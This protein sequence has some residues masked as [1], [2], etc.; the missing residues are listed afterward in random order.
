MAEHRPHPWE[1]AWKEGRWKELSPP[2]P[3]V[4]EFA[5]SLK[6]R[7][8]IRVLDLGC[9]AGRHTLFL[10]KHSFQVTALD[11]SETALRELQRRVDK[12]NLK[13]VA[14]V[15]HEMLELPFVD[16]YFDAIVSTNVLH[17]GT[18]AEIKRTLG[19]LFRIMKEGAAGFIIT[20]SKQ[21]FRYGD[22]EKI[23][24]D[25]YRFTDGDEKG[26]VHHFFDERELRSLF[27]RF[28]IMTLNEELF[29][30][31]KGNWAHFHLKMKKA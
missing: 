29:P 11:V 5:D 26:I 23:E 14:V 12:V 13:N 19:E 25:T 4:A 17:H 28:E 16:E 27:N 21:D 10:A 31:K 3:A 6:D 22:G 8:S 9:G 30:A 18:T 2:L 7:G 1:L 24:P 20:L 15:K